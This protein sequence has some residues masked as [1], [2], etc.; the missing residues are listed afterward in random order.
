MFAIGSYEW[1]LISSLRET[2]TTNQLRQ[3]AYQRNCTHTTR[4]TKIN[5]AFYCLT[6]QTVNISDYVSV[7]Y[8]IQI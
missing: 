8:K 3:D 7:L 4:S 5:Y 1:N 6:R 2:N